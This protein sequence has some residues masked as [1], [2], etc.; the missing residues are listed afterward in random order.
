MPVAIGPT[1]SG[2]LPIRLLTTLRGAIRC[3][4]CTEPAASDP[5]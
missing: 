4:D 5:V 2:V 1:G 3:I